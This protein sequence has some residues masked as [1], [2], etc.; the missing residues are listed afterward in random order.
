MDHM[1]EYFSNLVGVLAPWSTD[2]TPREG[3][4]HDLWFRAVATFQGF[5]AMRAPYQTP[6]LG[7]VAVLPSAGQPMRRDIS[8]EDLD[9]ELAARGLPLS[10]LGCDKPVLDLE[11]ASG[12]EHVNG[13]AHDA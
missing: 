10:V 2:G 8:P 11:T 7:A 12:S 3:R 6:R 9:R 5:L 13:N 4:D 1:V